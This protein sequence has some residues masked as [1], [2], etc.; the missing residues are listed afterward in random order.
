[1][2]KDKDDNSNHLVRPLGCVVVDAAYNTTVVVLSGFFFLRAGWCCDVVTMD[3][4]EKT[5]QT[6]IKKLKVVRD[7]YFFTT[8]TL[9]LLFS[10]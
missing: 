4:Q 7:L 5:E 1:M 3:D 6:V 2:T 9:S 8:Y 10:G